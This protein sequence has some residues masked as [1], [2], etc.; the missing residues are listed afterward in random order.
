M[1]TKIVQI[2]QSGEFRQAEPPEV[3]VAEGEQ[4]EFVNAGSGGTLLVLTPETAAILSPTPT[5]PVT[6][7]GGATVTYTFLTP[8]GSGYLA[9]VLPEGATPAPI[10]E[11]GAPGPVL[12]IFPST[13]RSAPV[14]GSGPDPGSHTGG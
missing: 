10:D 1:S 12:T 9:Q 2:A 5:S 6:I 7:A 11:A 13:D 8:T 3:F 14:G 4:V